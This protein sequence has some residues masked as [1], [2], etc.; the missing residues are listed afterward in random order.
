MDID[1]SDGVGGGA[2]VCVGDGDGDGVSEITSDVVHGVVLC[3]VVLLS[4]LGVTDEVCVLRVRIDDTAEARDGV[5]CSWVLKLGRSVSLVAT[6]VELFIMTVPSSP[7]FCGTTRRTHAVAVVVRMDLVTADGISSSDGVAVL[8]HFVSV[9]LVTAVAGVL[10]VAVV[11]VV[12][13][14]V[15]LVVVRLRL[16]LA[17]GVGFPFILVTFLAACVGRRLDLIVAVLVSDDAS[18][19]SSAERLAL[20]NT[21]AASVSAGQ[22]P[23]T[24]ALTRA[25]A[26]PL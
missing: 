14:L 11:V 2:D 10:V 7:S 16:L 1:A 23:V 19:L 6:E 15:V 3:S 20:T 21:V 18:L 17:C 25:M 26:L 5:D 4:A 8:S 13:T 22:F 24:T 12:G 9:V